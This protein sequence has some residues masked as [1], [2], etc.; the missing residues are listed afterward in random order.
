MSAKGIS[1]RMKVMFNEMAAKAEEGWRMIRDGRQDQVQEMERFF[2]DA[3][4]TRQQPLSISSVAQT[5]QLLVVRAPLAM[6]STVW[7]LAKG[8]VN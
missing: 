4:T 1:G 7:R 2:A 8:S 5:V 3:N 6:A